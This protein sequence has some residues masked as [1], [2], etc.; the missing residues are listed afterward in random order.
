MLPL[1][2]CGRS[3]KP[4]PA[5][6]STTVTETQT[7]AGAET[8]NTTARIQAHKFIPPPANAIVSMRRFSPVSLM[9]QTIFVR[10]DGNGLLT[11][12]IGEIGGAPHKAFRLSA[13]QLATLRRLLAATRSVKPGP[14][15]SGPYL[16]SLHIAGA[17][18]ISV[19]GPMPM[20]LTQLV[21]FLNGLMLTYCC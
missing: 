3:G 8:Q 7:I 11:S 12:L 14:S 13:G 10:P 20:R 16:Y 17:T 18:P 4:Q 19:E 2:A 9:W 15:R 1:A 5:A 6:R 21:N